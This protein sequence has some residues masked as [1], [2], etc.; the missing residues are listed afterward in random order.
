MSHK[1]PVSITGVWLR[2][3]E[4]GVAVVLVE[5][6]GGWVEIIRETEGGPYSHIC[7]PA[8][9]MAAL[10]RQNDNDPRTPRGDRA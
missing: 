10:F 7:E 6:G 4:L 8:G 9:I 2:Q 1:G 5:I 3:E